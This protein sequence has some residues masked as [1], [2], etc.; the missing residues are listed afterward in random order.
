MV[1]VNVIAG[2]SD[3]EARRL[4]T[5][6][7]MSFADLV[8]GA[9]RPMPPPID[10]IET[11]WTPEE[12]LHA[13]QMLRCSVIGG[14]ATVRAGLQALVDRTG[15]DELIVVS[16]VYDF[17]RRRRSVEIIAEAGRGGKN[18]YDARDGSCPPAALPRQE[19]AR[20]SRQVQ[21]A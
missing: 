17:D 5:S 20:V 4:A 7:Q 15:A 18:E 1:G 13:G 10:D 19:P 8:R 14:L 3:A 21:G 16:D 6:Q 9:R 2:E 11:Y 12:K